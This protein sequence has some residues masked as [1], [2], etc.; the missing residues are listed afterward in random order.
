MCSASNG[1]STAND[2]LLEDRTTFPT[3]LISFVLFDTV[4]DVGLQ[5][6]TSEKMS[7]SALLLSPIHFALQNHL[8][9]QHESVP[10]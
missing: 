2:I 4:E 8:Q 1:S 10:Y 9:D 6:P 5:C 3:S 7:A